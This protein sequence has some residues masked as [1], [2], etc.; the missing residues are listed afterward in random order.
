M[1]IHVIRKIL[2]FERNF[3]ALFFFFF[4]ASTNSLLD[5]NFKLELYPLFRIGIFYFSSKDIL[6]YNICIHTTRYIFIVKNFIS[7]FTREF[8]LVS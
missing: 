5:R 2:I 4:N 1:K 7:K 3:V 6:L 8:S